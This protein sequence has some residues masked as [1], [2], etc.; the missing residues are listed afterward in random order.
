MPN[1]VNVVDVLSGS[2]FM[3]SRTA[4]QDVDYFGEDTFLYCEER[5]LSYKLK[6]KGYNNI[7]LINQNYIRYYSISI[8]KSIKSRVKRY[9]I[10]Q[11]SRM[12]YFCK[13]LKINKIEQ[14]FLE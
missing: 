13:Y 3:I 2:F 10:L 5:I 14:I 1:D 8:N 7:L 6:S 11:K 9:K 4:I 12:V